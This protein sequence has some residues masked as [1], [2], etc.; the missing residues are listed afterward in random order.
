MEFFSRLW[1]RR[2]SP[3]VPSQNPDVSDQPF[4]L[5]AFSPFRAPPPHEREHAGGLLEIPGAFPHS[6]SPSPVPSTQ[7]A[8][9]ERAENDLPVSE[10]GRMDLE[11]MDVDLSTFPQLRT[12]L[13]THLHPRPVRSLPSSLKPTRFATPV[14]RR[15]PSVAS[16]NAASTQTMLIEDPWDE[17]FKRYERNPFGLPVSAVQL[18]TPTKPIPPGRVSSLFAKEW[19]AHKKL[20]LSLEEELRPGGYSLRA[21]RAVAK[22][23]AGDDLMATDIATCVKP[24]AWL[25]D[26]IINS[27]LGII[28]QYLSQSA[29]NAEPAEAP[30][31]HAFNTFFYT[32]LRQKGYDGVRR[33]AKRAKINGESLLGV[34]MVFVPVHESSHWTLMVIRPADRTIE[35]FDSLGSRGKRQVGIIKEWLRGELG[36]SYVDDEWS[37]LPSVSSQQ[38]NGSDCGVFLLTNAKAVALNIEPTAFGARDTSTLRKKIIAEIM[39]GGLH[40]EFD[41]VDKSGNVL[42]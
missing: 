6:R 39:N 14:S 35:Y 31:F 21:K 25:N 30:R 27:Y 37:V 28:I 29:G 36:A 34:D 4:S 40:G 32:T 8:Q 9:S 22:S 33:W 15:E 18:V 38:D 12:D 23:L 16:N 41:P 7:P 42:L 2:K 10:F 20:K 3:D 17:Q 26:E 11:S 13:G 19:D 1:S 24:L 5:A